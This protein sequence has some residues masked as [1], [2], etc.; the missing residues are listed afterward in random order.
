M[1]L[2]R[3]GSFCQASE[4]FPAERTAR[5]RVP[6]F[7]P[8]LGCCM[9]VAFAFVPAVTFWLRSAPNI[10]WSAKNTITECIH[11]GIFEYVGDHSADTLYLSHRARKS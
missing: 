5:S 3:L 10:I 11:D 2:L 8:H 1:I 7:Y 4:L 6:D 9:A